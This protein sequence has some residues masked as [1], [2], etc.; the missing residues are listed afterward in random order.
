MP[1]SSSSSSPHPPS[2]LFTY[3]SPR[4]DA[5]VLPE[6]KQKFSLRS[7]AEHGCAIRRDDK[8]LLTSK[9]GVRSLVLQFQNLD[10][11]LTFSDR[12][13]ELNRPHATVQRET[14]YQGGNDDDDDKDDDEDHFSDNEDENENSTSP[15]LLLHAVH[16]QELDTEAAREEIHSMIVRMLHDNDFLRFVHKVESYISSTED[17]ALMLEGLKNRDFSPL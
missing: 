1:S 12:F 4:K 8:I 6:L 10:D 17:G 3:A 7:D 11:C 5:I 9:Q 15:N 16:S 13:L 2:S 14:K